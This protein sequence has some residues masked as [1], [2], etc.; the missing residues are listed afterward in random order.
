M[1]FSYTQ[2]TAQVA[3]KVEKALGEKGYEVS[4]AAIEFTDPH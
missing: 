2:T 3:G 4:S 1:Y